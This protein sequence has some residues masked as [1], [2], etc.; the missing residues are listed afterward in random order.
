MILIIRDILYYDEYMQYEFILYTYIIAWTDD[1]PALLKIMNIMSHNSYLSCRFC[2]IKGIYS[3]K[4][5]HIYFSTD[6]KKTYTK[7]NNSTWLTHINEIK[8]TVTIKEKET[9]IKQYGNY[10]NH[11]YYWIYHCYK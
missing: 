2:N 6:L 7:K 1:I 9:L 3:E 8:T 10:N 4:H 11:L 5:K